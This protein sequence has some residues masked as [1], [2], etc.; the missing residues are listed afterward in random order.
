[1]VKNLPI[2]ELTT[3]R[4]GVS[5]A[6]VTS[7]PY[8]SIII[9]CSCSSRPHRLPVL[10]D[11]ED[12]YDLEA[13]TSSLI[14]SLSWPLWETLPLSVPKTL[15]IVTLKVVANLELSWAVVVSKMSHNA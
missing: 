13:V 10:G 4:L 6:S 14:L 5:L 11:R 15:S 2:F 9:F 8:G 12:L 7:H 3:F 1:M